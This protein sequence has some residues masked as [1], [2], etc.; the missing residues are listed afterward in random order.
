MSFT[1]SPAQAEQA[2]LQRWSY[3]YHGTR[4]AVMIWYPTDQKAEPLNGGPFTLN[5]KPGAPLPVKPLPL[6]LVSHGTGGSN[7][8]HHPLAEAL[9]ARNYIVAALTHP[10]D[11]YQDRSLAADSRYFN[12]R[13]NQLV[14]MLDALLADPK[15]GATIDQNRIGAIG[16]SIGGYSV[17]AMVG[18]RPDLTKLYEHCS[19]V[20]DD[21][22]CVYRD[23]TVGV[24]SPTQSGYA[25]AKEVSVDIAPPDRRVKSVALLAPMG[26]VIASKTMEDIK[27]SML[28]IG[29]QHD[30]VLP[31]K[32]HFDHLSGA[33]KKAQTSIAQGAGHFSFLAPINESFKA[34]LGEV[35]KDPAGLDRAAFNQRLG[36]QLISWFKE[37]L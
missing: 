8:G 18:A 25:L 34:G 29:A 26:S 30:E 4:V 5:A 17:A 16:H 21:P 37:T 24:S 9:A 20:K 36:Q 12:D 7:T 15:W 2:G 14:A 27:A 3:D 23:P 33:S 11:N 10:G 31:A 35:A 1:A 22:S 32:Y 19:T 13:P 6:L 28:I